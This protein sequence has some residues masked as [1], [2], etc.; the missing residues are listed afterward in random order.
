[1]IFK[2]TKFSVAI[3]GADYVFAA[4]T[5]RDFES[6]VAKEQRAEKPE[7]RKAVHREVVAAALSRA[8]DT[9]NPEDLLEMD[10]ALFNALFI[11]VMQA[12][13]MKLETKLGE[14]KASAN[15]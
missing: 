4:L 15:S 8:G 2:A 14:A 6:F 10:C 11:A 1:M 12:H 5:Q 9:T 13:G 3:A 7:D